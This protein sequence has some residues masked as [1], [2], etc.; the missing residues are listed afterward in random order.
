MV[1]VDDL[2]AWWRGVLDEDETDLEDAHPLGCNGYP[3]GADDEFDPGRCDCRVRPRLADIA[4]KRAILDRYQATADEYARHK[5][6]LT[7]AP[8]NHRL[9]FVRGVVGTTST[10]TGTLRDVIRLLA[11]AYADRPGWQEAWRP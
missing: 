3:L 8:Q 5:R 2:I 7:P 6:D 4:A 11:S 10:M 9:E 1:A